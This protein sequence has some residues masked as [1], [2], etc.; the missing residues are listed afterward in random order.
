MF[1]CSHVPVVLLH[2]NRHITLTGATTLI[3]GQVIAVGIFLTPASMARLLGSPFWLLVVWLVA[4]T[5]AIAGALVFG[6]FAARYPEAGGGYVYLR[7]AWGS[8]VAFLYGWKCCLVMDPGITAALATG[9][10]SYVGYLVPLSP[11]GLKVLAIAAIA[12]GAFVNIAGARLG[13]NVVTTLSIV[14]LAALATIVVAGFGL[15]RGDWNHFV[16]FVEQHAGARVL[17]FGGDKQGFTKFA[18]RRR[19]APDFELRNDFHADAQIQ[20]RAK[21][22]GGVQQVDVRVA[23]RAGRWSGDVRSAD[24]SNQVHVA[25][26]GFQAG[27]AL[28]IVVHDPFREANGAGHLQAVVGNPLAEVAE[29]ATILDVFIQLVEPGLDRVV[30]GLRRQIDLLGHT[31]LLPA[32][33]A[34][35]ERELNARRTLRGT[36]YSGWLSHNGIPASHCGS[37]GKARAAG[38][39]LAPTDSFQRRKCLACHG[40]VLAG[41][42]SNSL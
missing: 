18:E 42:S 34:H 13:A 1:L 24:R 32:D 16:P 28:G 40:W 7:E 2:M 35:V 21:P 3:V 37:G 22:L 14:K 36:C 20:Q 29:A 31:Q 26:R 39:Q 17:A 38:E 4:G 33:R 12:A 15:G 27:Q 5:M 6:E 30:A 10:A 23:R 11:L 19:E 41:R 25:F 8:R 9:L